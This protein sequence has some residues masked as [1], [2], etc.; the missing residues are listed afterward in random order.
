MG[1]IA[2]LLMFF[3]TACLFAAPSY[4]QTKAQPAAGMTPLEKRAS[5]NLES[6]RS[7]PLQLR[8]FLLQMPKGA[9]LHNHLSG[10]VYAESWIRAAAEDHLCFD[11]AAMQ[12][13]KPVFS[14]PENQ[15]SL[16]NG[17]GVFRA[18][19]CGNGKIPAADIYKDQNLY[20]DLIDSFS[21]R[22]FVP[23]PGITGHDQFFRTFARFGGIS[24]R[25]FGE[26][27][28]E[29]AT[30]AG[31]QNE[32]YMELMHTPEFDQ[33]AKAAYEIGWQDDLAKF[34]DALLAKGIAKDIA[35]AKQELD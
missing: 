9:D 8:N 2:K 26:W 32:Q 4:A 25:H 3:A 13:T 18:F 10:A 11:P 15:E 16:A 23:S 17:K 35:D 22:G 12:G 34:R 19:Y 24:H 33:S 7:N 28:D 30:R 31:R 29:V 5:L 20:D 1:R 21:M 6:A 27:L 14:K